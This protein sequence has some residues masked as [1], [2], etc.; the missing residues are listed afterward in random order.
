MGMTQ[1]IGGLWRSLVARF[2]WDE[3]VAGSNPV[4]PTEHIVGVRL[5]PGLPILMHQ[6]RSVAGRPLGS[7]PVRCIATQPLAWTEVSVW[8]PSPCDVNP[9]PR[10]WSVP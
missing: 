4:S 3:D 7:L 10:L 6:V 9:P 2:V 8:L 5:K 1:G